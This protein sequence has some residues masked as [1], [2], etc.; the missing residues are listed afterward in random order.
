MQIN[1][2]KEIFTQYFNSESYLRSHKQAFELL[3]KNRSTASVF[4]VGNGGSMAICSHMAEDF[5]KI[6]KFRAFS[7]SDP[8]LITCFANDYGYENAY[9]EWLKIYFNNNDIL[10]AISSSGKSKNILN[11]VQMAKEKNGNIITLSGF[12]ENNP[13]S[14]SGNVNFH[15]PV[16]NYGVVE[17]FHQVILHALLDELNTENATI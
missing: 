2:Y 4:F 11:A 5:A 8:S 15:I 9:A 6:G 12:D 14:K 10:I 1:I 3:E 16:S 17:C 7:M 13:L